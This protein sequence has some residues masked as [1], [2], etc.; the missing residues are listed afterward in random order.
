MITKMNP[1]KGPFWVVDIEKPIVA[2]PVAIDTNP[3]PSHKSVWDDCKG[4]IKE[5]WNYYPRGRVE[6]RRGKVIVS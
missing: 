5:A 3:V 4:N 6:I 1:K 2:C